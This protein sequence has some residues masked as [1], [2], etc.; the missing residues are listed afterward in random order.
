MSQRKIYM[1]I[2]LHIREQTFLLTVPVHN[3]PSKFVHLYR[4]IYIFYI[5]C[6]PPHSFGYKMAYVHT[7]VYVYAYVISRTSHFTFHTP[8]TTVKLCTNSW[9]G[10]LGPSFTRV[11]DNVFI[12]TFFFVS[13]PSILFSHFWRRSVS[14]FSLFPFGAIFTVTQTMHHKEWRCFSRDYIS[15]SGL[16]NCKITRAKIFMLLDADCSR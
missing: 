13:L 10:G 4:A 11:L 5:K 12:I 3:T 16:K 8:L 9:H 2:Y 1:Y 15:A 6:P 7:Y 14:W